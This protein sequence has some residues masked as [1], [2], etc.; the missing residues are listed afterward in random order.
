VQWAAAQAALT[1]AE[2]D[3]VHVWGLEPSDM[4]GPTG[5]IRDAVLPDLRKRLEEMITDAIGAS[6][7]STAWTLDIVQ[8]PPGPTLVQRARSADL[9][10]VGTGEHAGVRRLVAGS[11]SHHCLSHAH[12]PVVAV[13]SL[14]RPAAETAA[15]TPESVS[16][17]RPS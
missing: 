4:Y 10:V 9:L 17:S 11:V 1:G 12:V 13:P 16:G 8:G 7:G 6:T 5:D 3:I 15:R 14:A 2:L